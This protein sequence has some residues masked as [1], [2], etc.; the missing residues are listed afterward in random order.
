[1]LTPFVIREAVRF[2][3]TEN[4]NSVSGY[5]AVI[6]SQLLGLTGFTKL[7]D[8]HLHDI[9]ATQGEIDEIEAALREGVIL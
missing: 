1:M 6:Y 2:H 8:V 5:P 4:F 9:P 3:S 7:L